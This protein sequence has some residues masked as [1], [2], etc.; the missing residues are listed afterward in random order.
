VFSR[1]N[2]GEKVGQTVQVLTLIKNIKP[3]FTAL[4]PFSQVKKPLGLGNVIDV[5]GK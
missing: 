4:S 5:R 2:W 1:K 3:D